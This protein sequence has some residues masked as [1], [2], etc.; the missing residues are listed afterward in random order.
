MNSNLKL[1]PLRAT[2]FLFLAVLF[3][4]GCHSTGQLSAR[5]QSARLQPEHLRCEYLLNPVGLDEPKPRLSWQLVGK[6][7][8]QFQTAYQIQVSSSPELLGKGAADLWDSGKVASD[9]TINIA[10]AGTPLASRQRCFW[11]VGVWGQDGEQR[12]SVVAS[13]TMGLLRPDDWQA[14]FISVRDPSPLPANREGLYLPPAQQFRKEFTAPRAVK[15]ATLYATALGIYEL[16]LNGRR[17]GDSFFAPGWTDYRE[18]AYY[19]TYDVTPLVRTGTNVI[20][21][22]VADGWYAGY[23]G[24][25]LLRGFGPERL[26]RFMYGKT[27]AIMAQ[28]E[29]EHA[30]GTR[31]TWVTDDS[32]KGTADGP[33][34]EADFLMGESYDARKE[35]VGWSEAGF[36]D[37]QWPS[38][39]EASENGRVP[40]TFYETTNAGPPKLVGRPVD[41]GFIR[42]PR[43]EAF[44]GV[45]VRVTQELKPVAITSP[46][47]GVHIFDFGQNFAGNV[48]LQVKGP[49]G[50]RLQLRY[51]EML[52]PDGRLM[53][54]NLRK[55]RATDYYIL[56]GGGGTETWQPRFTFHGFQYV[57]VTGWPGKPGLDALTGLV[58][59]SDTPMASGFEC[60]D[61]MVNRLFQNVL[62][63][64]RAN[65][66]DLPTDC[67]QRDERMGWTGDAQIYIRTATL[68]ADVAA[69]FTKWL[70]ELM[71]AQRPGGTF[72]G[73]A[74]F[75]FQTGPDFGTAWCDAGVI[76]PWTLRQAYNDTRIIE[77][78]WPHLVR[79]MEWRQGRATN[80]LGV[81]GGHG[82]G[83]WLSF[84][85][86]TPIEYIDTVYFAGSAKM[87]AEMA[88]AIG[89]TCE[90]TSS[91]LSRNNISARTA[92]SR[93]TIRPRMRWRCPWG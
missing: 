1:T 60:S 82:W 43:L 17:V 6:S 16:H 40:A 74:P 9:E 70:R 93:W 37:S 50:T 52:H 14:D 28:L 3:G 27:P 29:I 83:D 15:R 90:A 21:A 76:C 62:W 19:Q 58:L 81:A 63:T 72:P 39:V 12:W 13:W 30:D 92:R 71:E 35:R 47:N 11:R 34:R 46:T 7:R 53:T 75:P 25:G 8:G 26:G 59:H 65:F 66:I 88:E 57:E 89:K 49:A 23:V 55:A 48:R 51:G 24:F 18:R 85:N 22:W 10:Y 64:Q 33:V 68:N 67:P 36:D 87:M 91:P 41:L 44:P 45:P 73:Y 69:F 61:P 56:R 4:A 42:P 20:G 86:K 54:E 80:F 78:C 77:R 84:G 32:W 79:F 38:A 31:S 5:H 2:G